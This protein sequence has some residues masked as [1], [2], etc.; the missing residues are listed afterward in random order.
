MTQFILGQEA[1]E[2][3]GLDPSVDPG[4]E[5]A[6]GDQEDRGDDQLVRFAVAYLQVP[7]H[8]DAYVESRNGEEYCDLACVPG[9]EEDRVEEDEEEE[10]TALRGDRGRA[11]KRRQDDAAERGE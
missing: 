4:N 11:Q 7:V 10:G 2:L 5:R 9:G 1:L 8:A 6:D 3:R